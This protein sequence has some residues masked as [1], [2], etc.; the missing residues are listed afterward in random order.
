[1]T[2]QSLIKNNLLM[3]KVKDLEIDGDCGNLT[4]EAIFTYQAI[5]TIPHTCDVVT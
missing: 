4:K 2:I 5:K 1:M 3:P